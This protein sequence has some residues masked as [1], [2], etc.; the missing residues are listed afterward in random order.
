MIGVRCP[1]CQSNIARDDGKAPEVGDTMICPGCA[2]YL[3]MDPEDGCT[4]VDPKDIFVQR[5]ELHAALVES[6]KQLILTWARGEQE[7][8]TMFAHVVLAVYRKYG[9]LN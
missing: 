4:M 7:P 2:G 1:F 5:P 8:P 3:F 6:R 9:Q